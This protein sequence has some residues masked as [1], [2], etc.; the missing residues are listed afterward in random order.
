MSCEQ[1]S[2]KPSHIFQPSGRPAKIVHNSTENYPKSVL[3]TISPLSHQII[4]LGAWVDVS[5]YLI[6]LWAYLKDTFIS[7]HISTPLHICP[8]MCRHKRPST[9]APMG[10]IIW[11]L[12]CMYSLGGGDPVVGSESLG[13]WCRPQAN[14]YALKAM[15]W[16]PACGRPSPAHT[17]GGAPPP[18]P[19]PPS[20]HPR[21]R[22]RS[23]P[24]H[25]RRTPWRS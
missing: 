19:T 7:E 24:P 18:P 17:A 3:Q 9:P 25:F 21:G 23:G 14:F 20:P 13:H 22:S 12:I 5:L 4:I 15:G 11:V 2:F 6:H 16:P 8:Y 1:L 10:D